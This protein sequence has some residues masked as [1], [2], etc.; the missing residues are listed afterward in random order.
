MPAI[1]GWLSRVPATLSACA[2]V[3]V[4][5]VTRPLSALLIRASRLVT[6]LS[7]VVAEAEVIAS[8]ATAPVDVVPWRDLRTLLTGLSVR[9][10]VR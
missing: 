10:P 9:A 3:R 1:G 6:T 4:P 5:S 7:E 8:V 2:W